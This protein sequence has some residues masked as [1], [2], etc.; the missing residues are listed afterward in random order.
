M[1]ED[2]KSKIEELKAKEEELEPR[3]KEIEVERE[4]ELAEVNK[5]YDHIVEDAK[6][7]VQNL[8]DKIMNELVDAYIKAILDEFDTKRS[9]SEYSLTERFKQFK[10]E[11]AEIEMFPHELVEK[12]E[13]V[14]EGEPIDSLAYEID[15]IEKQYK[16]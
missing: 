13:K 8:K 4:K 16:R 2:I 7:E 6:S 12:L 3:L 10:D 11:I 9:V 14:I 1:L 5:K 15:K